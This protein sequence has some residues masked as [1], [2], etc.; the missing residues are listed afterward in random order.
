[1]TL[2]TGVLKYCGIGIGVLGIGVCIPPVISYRKN[3]HRR[4]RP[5]GLR[6]SPR[7]L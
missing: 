4:P 6:P 5:E 2:S 3:T 1:M 7:E